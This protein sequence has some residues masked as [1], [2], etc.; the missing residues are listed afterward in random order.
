MHAH[1]FHSSHSW[2]SVIPALCKG[3]HTQEEFRDQD[4]LH[5]A[6]EDKGS[7]KH[8]RRDFLRAWVS[9]TQTEM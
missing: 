2:Q 5:H 3:K 6:E 7:K 4:G 1:P 9:M 8:Y